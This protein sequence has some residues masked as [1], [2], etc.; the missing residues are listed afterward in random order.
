MEEDLDSLLETT[1]SQ[2]ASQLEPELGR[3][4]LQLASPF[5]Q[6]G[7]ILKLQG[8]LR[9]VPKNMLKIMVI[10]NYEAKHYLIMYVFIIYNKLFTLTRKY[11]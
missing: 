6:G 10:E 11:F 3:A 8:N 2:Q 5:S 9:D 4:W 7:I 1:Q